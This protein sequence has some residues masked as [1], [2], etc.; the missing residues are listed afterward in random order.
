VT[1]EEN[2]YMKAVQAVL[3]F[4][5]GKELK[6][7]KAWFAKDLQFDQEIRSRFLSLHIQATAG[8][9]ADW[10]NSAESCLALV[11]VLDQFSRNMFRGQPEAFTSDSA[12]LEAAQH[13]IAH[14]FDQQLPPVQRQFF[15]LPL[16]H[17]E[18]LEFQHQSVKLFEQF[19][20][21]PALSDSY[22]SALR[23]RETIERFGR[24]PHRNMILGRQSTVEELEF[25][26]QPGSS[27]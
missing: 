26:K 18:D 13:G 23:H 8:E 15:Y 4:W 16:E 21:D 25:L 6:P 27:F 9:L 5:F 11:I 1:G 17:T 19:K 12:A 10:K 20:D 2:F 3:E 22:Q 24:F 14:Q 7:R